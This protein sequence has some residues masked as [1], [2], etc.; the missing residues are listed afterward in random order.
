MTAAAFRQRRHRARQRAGM[1]CF[2]IEAD[3]VALADRLV[4]D[5]LLNPIAAD[6]AQSIRQAL[7]H[8][9]ALVTCNHTPRTGCLD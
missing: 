8:A 3:E 2:R 7:E 4:R 6:D 5:G 9:V 1:R